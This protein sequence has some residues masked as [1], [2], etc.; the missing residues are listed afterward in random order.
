MSF[1]FILY[2]ITFFAYPILALLASLYI[3]LFKYRKIIYGG[4]LILLIHHAFYVFDGISIQGD[5]ADYI[6]FSL[7]YLILILL[8]LI[9][10]ENKTPLF[11]FIRILGIMIILFGYI[12]LF[13]SIFLIPV[14][15]QD[16]EADR[17]FSVK[18]TDKTYQV[19]RYSFGFATLDDVNYTF[20]TYK[21]YPFFPFEKLLNTT[22]LSL[23]KNELNFQDPNFE[24]R[25]KEEQ[26]ILEF[27]SGEQF[28]Q[29][30]LQ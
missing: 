13:F 23:M 3:D 6:V 29:T 30:K 22:Q 18:S 19:R 26:N 1:T 27:R 28:Y 8:F 16:F 15:A 12:Q 5:Y 24:V 17:I 10:F 11:K 25:I 20:E 9:H 7:D 14:F 2:L 21:I 4:I